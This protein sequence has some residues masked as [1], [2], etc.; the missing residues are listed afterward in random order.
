MSDDMM[1]MTG[2][3]IMAGASSN[4]LVS[5]AQI[6]AEGAGRKGQVKGQIMENNVTAGLDGR[7]HVAM[8]L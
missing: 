2:C 3:P 8:F 5:S 6:F 1:R 4:P 7:F